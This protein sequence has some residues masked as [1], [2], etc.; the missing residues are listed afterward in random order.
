VDDTKVGN[1]VPQFYRRQG[2]SATDW[3][4]PGGTDYT[5]TTVRMQ[6]GA[7][8]TT[9]LE[10]TTVTFP[11]AFSAQ[12]QVFVQVLETSALDPLDH[13]VVSAGSSSFDVSLYDELGT[14][15]SRPIW[16]LAIGPE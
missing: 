9:A 12:P 2:G 16:W 1:R 15:V 5:P 11:Q 8:Y 4:I 13:I 6:S 14:I 7:I 3:G 10:L